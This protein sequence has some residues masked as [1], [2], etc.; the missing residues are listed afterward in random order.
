MRRREFLAGAASLLALAA[1]GCAT[2]RRTL[3]RP[4]FEADPFS[5]GV[6]S[7]SPLADGFVLWTR[8]AP[9][10][11]EPGGGMPPEV[12]DVE[13]VLAAEPDMKQ[14]VRRGSV[15][16]T[17]ELAH[18]V[19]V[20]LRGLEPAR[21]YWYRFRAGDAESRVGRTATAPAAGASLER[22]R[23]AYAS[24]QHY[25]QGHFNSYHH[26]VDD[27]LDLVIH[28]GDY[29]YEIPSWADE[30]R[31]HDG[32]EPK[33]LDAY[34]RRHALYK[35]DPALQA[36]HAAC[37][38][39]VT[40]DDHEVDNDYAGDASQDGDDPALFRARRQAA[41]QAYY[42]HMPLWR[43]ALPEGG[44]MRLF[45]RLGFGD[46]V[47]ISLLD[48][49]QYRS[50]Q[51]CGEPGRLGGRRITGCRERLDPA[52]T[53]Y[54]AEQERWLTNG[55]GASRAR[56]NVLAQQMLMAELDQ[57]PGPGE[58]FWSDGWDGY[59][60]ARERLLGFLGERGVSNPIVIGGDIHSF[61]ATELRPR[62]RDPRSPVVATEFV[63]TSISSAGVR[64]DE[65]AELLPENPHI[66]FFESRRRGYVRCEVT[67]GR[68]RTDFRVVESVREPVSP[69]STL[70]SFT[71]EAGRPGVVES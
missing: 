25:E 32:P 30:V 47:E 15:P 28:L 69:V 36:A 50:D 29:I 53:L 45:Q 70:A 9:E 23:F 19:H 63:G 59:P 44:R 13:W 68:W 39:A 27:D 7:G 65:F 24:C 12:V 18:S 4:R 52:R 46:L 41:Y 8:L 64:Y 54:G 3:G 21:P 66:R 34:R 57:Q 26:M 35:T 11:L 31:K 20:E 22:F 48:G 40:W 49:R 37:P 16:A 71:V 67:P 51:P 33:T 60:A 58:S 56:W 43:V 42:E 6:A 55:L 61:W 1:G 17:P 62:F 38:W 14:I 10:P 5:L 2:A